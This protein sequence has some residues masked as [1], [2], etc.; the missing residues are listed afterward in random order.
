MDTLDETGTVGLLTSIPG[1]CFFHLVRRFWNQIFTWVSVRFNESARL[2]L[3]HTERYLVVLNLF[4]KATSC[5]YVNAVRA[6]RGFPALEE[7]ILL[8]F[9]SIQSSLSLRRSSSS[10]MS[11]SWRRSSSAS[12]PILN[13]LQDKSVAD[14]GIPAKIKWLCYSF[15]IWVNFLSEIC[16]DNLCSISSVNWNLN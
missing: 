5:S 14:S 2:S 10:S 16:S 12:D 8:H 11:S 9:L 3:S 13:F 4:S 6:R 7:S 1:F 15:V